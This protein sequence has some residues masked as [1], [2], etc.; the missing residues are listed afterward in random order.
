MLGRSI[1]RT[2]QVTELRVLTHL[3]GRGK[4]GRLLRRV[5]PFDSVVGTFNALQTAYLD[6]EHGLDS[7]NAQRAVLSDLRFFE[8]WVA[9]RRQL[10]PSWVSPVHRAAAD[11]IPL[12][13]REVKNFAN[14]CQRKASSLEVAIETGVSNVVNFPRGDVVGTAYRNRRLRNASK[15][16]QWLITSLTTM[17]QDNVDEA[18]L[19]EARKRLIERSFEKQLLPDMKAREPG[20]LHPEEA[21]AFRLLLGDKSRFPS[22]PVGIRD[23]LILQLLD[24]GLRA[25]ELLKLKV[26]DVNDAYVVDSKRVIGVVEIARRP[27]DIDD[28]RKHEPAVKTRPGLLP[29][30][31][32]LAADLIDYVTGPRRD[33]IDARPGGGETPYL[34]VNHIGRHIGSAMGQRNLNRLVGKLQGCGGLPDTFSPHTLRHTHLTEMYDDLRTKGRASEDIRDAL[35]GRGRWAPNSSMPSLY[36][37]RSLMR[38]SSDF[39]EE[40]DKKL[41]RG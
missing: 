32:R 15:Y 5:F 10:D 1:P 6:H 37:G 23:K 14:W 8:S 25:G 19:F 21:M 11:E 17:S 16:L 36:T 7:L 18:S 30:P 2:R 38:E 3:V 31:R 39:V 26:C 12:T 28:A 33:A 20:S 34:F 40:R 27:N 41:S 13:A 4:H 35:I 29:I 24:Q 22:T 9:M